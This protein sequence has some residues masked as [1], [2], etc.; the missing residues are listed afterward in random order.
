MDARVG[1]DDVA[2][3]AG[4]E[5]VR[6]VLLG[7]GRR[8]D[9]WGCYVGD[10]RVSEGSRDK[11]RINSEWSGRTSASLFTSL[12]KRSNREDSRTAPLSPAHSSTPDPCQSSS[13]SAS[14][15]PPHPLTNHPHF[16]P[17]NFPRAPYPL[18]PTISPS[19]T[20]HRTH[21]KALLHHPPP[22]PAEIP[23]LFRRRTIAL[24]RRDPRK[25]LW[26]IPRGHGAK[27]GDVFLDG[28]SRGR[29]R[30]GDRRLRAKVEGGKTRQTYRWSES[31]SMVS[32]KGRRMTGQISDVS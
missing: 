5:G 32:R 31:R 10:R 7:S 29:Q 17:T 30:A 4:L 20:P 28:R 3:L 13:T 14:L 27:A 1:L 2:E 21:L 18:F 19:P 15:F 6:R 24:R 9:A 22:K 8:G 26:H 12:P 23:T 11:G 16:R 25:L